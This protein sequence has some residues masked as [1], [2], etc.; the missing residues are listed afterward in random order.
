MYDIVNK[1]S[2]LNLPKEVYPNIPKFYASFSDDL[3]TLEE[4]KEKMG[5]LTSKGIAITKPSQVKVFSL[6]LDFI[7]S[8]VEQA[9]KLG[10]LDMF[11]SDPTRISSTELFQR[12]SY[13]MSLNETLKD[14]KG[15]YSKILFNKKE[16]DRRYGVDYL[17]KEKDDNVKVETTNNNEENVVK[18][19]TISQ[20]NT[21]LDDLSSEVEKAMNTITAEP[22]VENPVKDVEPIETHV[23]VASE[24]INESP[25]Q[26]VTPVNNP[27]E[28]EEINPYV[29]ALSKEQT[30]R[31]DDEMLARFEDLTAHLK[32]VLI[33]LG[34][35]D[36]IDG[37]K[38]DNLIKLLTSG[39]T[40]KR[41]ILYYTL[42][43]NKNLTDEEKVSI[44]KAIDNELKL[45]NN[46]ELSL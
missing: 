4:L 35:S 43:Y 13:V 25:V 44:Y 38:S 19:E 16:F 42:T 3:V 32:N 33:T 15:K 21:S 9:E 27:S 22:I 14:E 40:E 30:I 31:L 26:E 36:E 7:K 28:T 11:I 18:E 29:M 34:Y 45:T 10:L 37:T 2:V 24:P 5:Y 8:Q 41:E 46:G 39:V 6:P 1:I 17:T 12:L 23:E 20:T